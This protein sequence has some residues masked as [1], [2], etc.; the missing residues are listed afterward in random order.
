MVADYGDASIL[1]YSRSTSRSKV[2]HRIVPGCYCKGLVKFLPLVHLGPT[3]HKIFAVL[4]HKFALTYLTAQD[5]LAIQSIL[6]V[7]TTLSKFKSQLVEFFS[8]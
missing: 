4:L 5:R 6:I 7:C 3:H 2:A 8:I 1:S